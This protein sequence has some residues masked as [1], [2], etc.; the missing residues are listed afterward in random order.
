MTPRVFSLLRQGSSSKT[1]EIG[2][3]TKEEPSSLVSK[4]ILTATTRLGIKDVKSKLIL[5]EEKPRFH[6][7]FS[8][9][10]LATNLPFEIERIGERSFLYR[11]LPLCLYTEEELE[12]EHPIVT[13][14]VDELCDEK[15][16]EIGIGSHGTLLKYEASIREKIILPNIN[17]YRWTSEKGEGYYI[18]VGGDANKIA[19]SFS[20]NHNDATYVEKDD[21][22]NRPIT[23]KIQCPEFYQLKGLI[24]PRSKHWGDLPWSMQETHQDY[25]NRFDY[26]TSFVDLGVNTYKN[27]WV[28]V[29][30][31]EKA[32]HLLK[33]I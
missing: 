11:K 13:Q 22:M 2:I 24:I 32:L 33:V 19:V 30:F 5:P 23:L 9:H 3:Q 17:N 12:V 7:N 10:H 27:Q 18:G 8:I 31:N 15:Y 16:K 14:T 20:E 6:H 25:V 26:L 28:Q 21:F 4:E 29:K 1:N